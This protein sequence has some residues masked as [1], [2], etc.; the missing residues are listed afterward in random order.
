MLK[1]HS[2]VKIILRGQ[3]SNYCWGSMQFI[4]FMTH[5]S[6][7]VLLMDGVISHGPE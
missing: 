1:C 4:F 5:D 6:W 3:Q 2:S 7:L